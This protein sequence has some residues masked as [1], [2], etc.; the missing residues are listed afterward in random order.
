MIFRSNECLSEVCEILLPI[1]FLREDYYLSLV[2]SLI[3]PPDIITW[4]DMKQEEGG[5]CVVLP[6]NV[7]RATFPAILR[8]LD[9]AGTDKSPGRCLSSPTSGTNPT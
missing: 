7:R 9:L 5:G 2:S 8:G 6:V 3:V 1:L 4:Y